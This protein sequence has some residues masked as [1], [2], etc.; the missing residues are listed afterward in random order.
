MI[1]DTI[2]GWFS[3]EKKS[4]L[5]LERQT[6]L[7]YL[8]LELL[9]YFD[10]LVIVNTNILIDLVILKIKIVIVLIKY[11]TLFI[12]NLKNLS[13][14]FCNDIVFNLLNNNFLLIYIMDK[15]HVIGNFIFCL[16]LITIDYYFIKINYEI[17]EHPYFYEDIRNVDIR[18]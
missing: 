3:I 7:N 17:T 10:R 14:I 15:L 4:I 1:V 11:F 9:L 5:S 18:I 16:F 13:I 2:V 12:S 8:H 6:L